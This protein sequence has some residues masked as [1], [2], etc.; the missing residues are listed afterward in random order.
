MFHRYKMLIAVVAALVI[1]GC[2]GEG[3]SQSPQAE[4]SKAGSVSAPV[5]GAA[6]KLVASDA[7]KVVPGSKAEVELS[8]APVVKSVAPAVVNVYS[9]KVVRQEAS[10]FFNDPFFRRFFGDRF[11]PSVPQERVQQS[12]G[13]GVILRPDGIIVTNNHVIG[14][15]DTIT[16]ALADRREFEA[17]VILKDESTDLAVLRIDAGDEALPFLELRDSDTVEV[18]DIVLAVGNPFGV[19]Q[20]VTSGIVSAVART[21]A[22][23]SDYQFFL[24]TDAA[25]N[26]GNSGGALVTLD[27]RLVGINTAIY[28][29]SGGSMGIGFAIPA[30]MV[31]VVVSAAL[32]DGKIVRPWF[33]AAGQP[34]TAD[35]AK[36]LGIDRPMGVLI[37]QVYD[38]SPAAKAGV[39]VGDIITHV[40]GRP[41]DSPQGLMFR[42]RVGDKDAQGRVPVQL[43]RDGKERTVMVSVAPAPEVP[44]RNETVLSSDTFLGGLKIANLNPAFAEELGLDP[45]MRGVI[46]LEM[47]ADSPAR[48]YRL[49][50]PGDLIV[51]VNG[52]TVKLVDDVVKALKRDPDSFNFGFQRGNRIIRCAMSGGTLSCRQ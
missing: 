26:P 39:K 13:S 46:V 6:P 4:I 44:P 49:L 51:E 7:V 27:G 24:Q 14:D 15:A 2:G 18:G 3:E 47:S 11:G 50:R 45:M 32:S 16:V 8:Y 1:A 48:R 25:I 52:Q 33:G 42:M 40:A 31:G 5:G 30:N 36:S 12:L 28:S 29:R 17:E 21:A 19:G 37:D 34:V 20:T 23:I 43:L 10:P 41:V 22:D 38:G 35:I 9:R